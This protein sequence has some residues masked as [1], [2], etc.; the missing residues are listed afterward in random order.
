M[1][2]TK[3]AVLAAKEK[4]AAKGLEGVALEKALSKIAV[5]GDRS[6]P[7]YNLFLVIQ[8]FCSPQVQLIEG[9]RHFQK[10]KK[11]LGNK[12]NELAPEHIQELVKLY[13]KCQH[14]ATS[15]KRKDQ[16]EAQAEIE[17]GKALKQQIIAAL[18]SMDRA[19]VYQSRKPF[20][21]A[22]NQALSAAGLRLS[23]QLFIIMIDLKW[24]L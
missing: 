23:I 21:K 19:V 16:Q 15:K 6:Q 22:L 17:V 11:S 5:G 8:E 3:P 2:P 24:V 9:T 10:M 20:L 13:G 4:L 7:L 14:D 1:E 18:S 12:R